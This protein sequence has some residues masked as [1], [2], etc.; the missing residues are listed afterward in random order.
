MSTKPP[1]ANKNRITKLQQLKQYHPGELVD[2]QGSSCQQGRIQRE[3]LE[4]KQQDEG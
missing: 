3:I 1:V 4:T 2:K